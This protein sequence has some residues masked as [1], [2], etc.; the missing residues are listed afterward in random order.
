[1]FQVRYA[2]SRFLKIP[3]HPESSKPTNLA[4]PFG[5]SSAPEIFQKLMSNLGGQESTKVNG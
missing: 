2:P 5:I 1:M 4:T 3:L